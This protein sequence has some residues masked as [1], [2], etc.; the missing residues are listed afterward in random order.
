MHI[1]VLRLEVRLPECTTR[2][3]KQRRLQA[4]CRKVRRYFNVSVDEVDREEFIDQ[5]VLAIAAVA[6]DRHSARKLLNRVADAFSVHPALEVLVA[7]VIE[8]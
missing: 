5:A 1:A 4:V 7:R 6:R 8:L 2:R 3:Q